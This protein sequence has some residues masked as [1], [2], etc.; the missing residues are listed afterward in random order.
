MLFL[1][2]ELFA[3]HLNELALVIEFPEEVS[4]KLM[5]GLRR[6]TAVHVEGDSEILKRFLDD[7]VVAVNHVLRCAAFLLRADG[8]WNSMF[9]A[10]SHKQ[11][12]LALQT[13]IA[14]IDI[15]RHIHA[16]QVSD[17]HRAVG[18]RKCRRDGGSFE[19]LFHF[20]GDFDLILQSYKII[21]K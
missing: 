6:G 2:V 20:V 3:L 19:F 5:M 10:A 15:C 8:D 4:C 7:I 12:L 17:M 14:C 16:G 1:I 18:V 11:H 13:K 9:V 21:M